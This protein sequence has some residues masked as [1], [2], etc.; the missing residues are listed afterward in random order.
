MLRRFKGFTLIELLIVVAIIAILAAIAV[1]NFLEAQ[2]RSK[3]SRVKSDLR[4]YATALESY[5]IDNN[6]YPSQA[7][8]QPNGQFG[9]GYNQMGNDQN[10]GA[11]KA[12]T[13]RIKKNDADQLMTLT[14]PIAYLSTYFGDPFADTKGAT[15]VYSNSPYGTGWL[16]WSWGPDADESS[17]S[18]SSSWIV[19]GDIAFNKGGAGAYNY[20]PEPG[21]NETYYNASITVPSPLLVGA[22]YDPTNGTTSSGDV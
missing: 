2:T 3:V 22:T 17:A 8:S 18:Y 19:G 16:M 1:P 10:S 21:V 9:A 5:Y 12:S 7:S 11:R 15:F 13:F 14:T 4:T 20:S 6:T